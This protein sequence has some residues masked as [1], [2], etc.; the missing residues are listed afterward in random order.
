VGLGEIRMFG[1]CS[2]LGKHKA[3]NNGAP[4]RLRTPATRHCNARRPRRAANMKPL[5]APSGFLDAA[6]GFCLHRAPPAIPAGNQRLMRIVGV[7]CF[8]VVPERFN[9]T[10]DTTR[11]LVVPDKCVEEK[12]LLARPGV[13][14][15][16]KL[17]DD[18]SSDDPNLSLPAFWFIK[19]S[20]VHENSNASASWTTYAL[21]SSVVGDGQ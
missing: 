15:T 16:R 6:R 1:R 8:P 20:V 5:P 4:Q 11:A 21:T 19:R 3:L 7:S 17:A 14:P 13:Q 2:G 12:T 9:A 18:A 10:S